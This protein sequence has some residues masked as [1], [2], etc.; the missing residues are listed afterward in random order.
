MIE[1][2]QNIYFIN[3]ERFCRPFRG[4]GAVV[5]GAGPAHAFYFATYEHSK[6]VMSNL[7]PQYN[8]FNYGM[9]NF[10]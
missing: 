4:I 8:H 5:A 2:M 10:Q 7:F 1:S 9:A 3:L 6:E